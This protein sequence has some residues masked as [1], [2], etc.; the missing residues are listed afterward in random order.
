MTSSSQN[1]ARLY[2]DRAGGTSRRS[3]NPPAV[4]FSTHFTPKSEPPTPLSVSE[5]AKLAVA[6]GFS[7]GGTAAA[8]YFL[9]RISYQHV[10]EYFDLFGEGVHRSLHDVHRVILFD[11]KLQSIILEYIGLFELQFRAQYS[12][13]M[14]LE[15]GAFAHRNPRNYKDLGHFED[16]LKKYED[17]FK[18]QVRNSRS[19]AQLYEEYGDVPLWKAVEFM[20]F[21]T[22]SMLYQNTRSRQVRTSVSDSFDVTRRE[23]ESW[24]RA[25]AAV[26]N[27]CAHFNRL[28][29]RPLERRPVSI[30]G[31][32]SDNGSFF[33]A[34]LILE[35]LLSTSTVFMDDTSLCYGVAFY[36][37]IV[38]LF[39]DY[40]DLL[41]RCGVPDDWYD[42]MSRED[43]IG[44]PSVGRDTGIPE[45]QGAQFTVTLGETQ[46]RHRMAPLID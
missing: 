6:E 24:M 27:R 10:S 11:R 18:R 31:I 40:R 15:R 43:L 29:G 33:Y 25:L 42:L 21:G 39:S 12:Y 3:G 14:S 20:S 34:I 30:Q 37:R 7:D 13:A 16:F 5:L 22:L 46:G 9:N 2:A 4:H 26:R 17:E 19:V 35:K 41:P 23:L 36:R 32:T 45:R 28:C 38:Q 44:L 8:E 1:G